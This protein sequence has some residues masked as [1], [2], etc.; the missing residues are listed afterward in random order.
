MG[1][2]VW[3]VVKVKPKDVEKWT[4]GFIV[5]NSTESKTTW[6]A[7]LIDNNTKDWPLSILGPLYYKRNPDDGVQL[8]VFPEE[9]IVYKRIYQ[10]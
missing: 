1:L 2:K 5:Y 4:R 7:G 3:F 10:N 9:G 8:V 6:T